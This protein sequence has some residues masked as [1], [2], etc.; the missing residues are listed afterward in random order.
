MHLMVTQLASPSLWPNWYACGENGSS[1][2]HKLADVTLTATV[3]GEFHCGWYCRNMVGMDPHTH[4]YTFSQTHKYEYRHALPPFVLC[5]VAMPLL[6]CPCVP[7][8]RPNLLCH[9][10]LVP[11]F[12]SPPPSALISSYHMHSSPALLFPPVAL[13]HQQHKEY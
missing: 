12:S 5:R 6:S 13:P 2:S 1:Q 10:K 9:Q 4:T 7:Q 11:F 8:G 3:R